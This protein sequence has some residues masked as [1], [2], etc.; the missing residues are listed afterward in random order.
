MGTTLQVFHSYNLLT[1]PHALLNNLQRLFNKLLTD[2]Y[3]Q[4]INFFVLHSLEVLFTFI[5]YYSY[6]YVTITDTDSHVLYIV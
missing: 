5:S 3:D 2:T 1:F 4:K 6:K